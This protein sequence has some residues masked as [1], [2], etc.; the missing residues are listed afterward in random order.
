MNGGAY[1][2]VTQGAY[3]GNTSVEEK[4]RLSAGELKGRE[5]RYI[6]LPFFR[7]LLNVM[8]FKISILL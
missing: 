4:L 3:M 8:Y 5:I 1:M 7:F 2:R 6:C